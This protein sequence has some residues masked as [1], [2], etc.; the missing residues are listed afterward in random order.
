MLIA[1]NRVISCSERASFLWDISLLPDVKKIYQ[2]KGLPDCSAP[3]NVNTILTNEFE[4][5]SSNHSLHDSGGIS[6]KLQVLYC[7]AGHKVCAGHIPTNSTGHVHDERSS[8][9]DNDELRLTRS[10]FNDRTNEKLTKQR[11]L[12][13]SATLLPLRRIMLLGT[14]DGLIRVIL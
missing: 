6:K 1:R 11:I 9:V 4:Q 10:F 5:K 14:S 3:M 8:T 13:S 12:I 2:I 7:L